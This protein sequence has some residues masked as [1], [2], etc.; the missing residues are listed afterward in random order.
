MFNAV[1]IDFLFEMFENFS[2]NMENEKIPVRSDL[3]PLH[4]QTAVMA[5]F[6]KKWT[7]IRLIECLSLQ[8]KKLFKLLFFDFLKQTGINSA[9]LN[10]H[11]VK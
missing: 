5:V 6:M 2:K 9:C 8:R 11:G 3:P 7:S 10:S 1:Y 4:L